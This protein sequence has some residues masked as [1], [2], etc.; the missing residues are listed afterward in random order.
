[1]NCEVKIKTCNSCGAQFQTASNDRKY[2][3]RC[4]PCHRQFEAEKR[5][6]RKARGQRTGG[7][8]VPREYHQEYQR[9]YSSRP[10]VKL[11]RAERARARARNPL[12]RH[13]HK[14]RWL[15][16]RAIASGRLVRQPCEICG[17]T[18]VDAH[19]DDYGK[20]LDVRW[21]CR[22]HH[23]AHHA[24]ATPAASQQEKR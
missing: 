13:K 21:L 22:P 20:P 3:A 9:A 24:K 7:G 8:A 4:R 16:R 10:D 12:E 11:A 15:A 6:R 14:A 1:M 23:V 18:R 5:A 2:S 19:H 17:E